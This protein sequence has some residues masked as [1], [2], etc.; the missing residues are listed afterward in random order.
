MKA[1]LAAVNAKYIHSNLAVYC[2]RSYASRWREQIEIAEYTINQYTDD[3]LRD[4]YLKQ[5]DFLAFSCYIWNISQVRELAAELRKLCPNMPIWAGGPE[6]SYDSEE[7]LKENPAFTGIMAGEGE[8]TFYKLMEYYQENEGNLTDVRGLVF[9]DEEGRIVHNGP[10]EVIDLDEL[11]FP[12][13]DMQDFEHKIVYYETSRGCPFSCS[14]CLSS[15]DK[16]VRFRS[17]ELVKNELMFF[18]EHEVPQV[19][20]VDR[21][22]NCNHGQAVEIWKYIA[23]HDRGITNFHF[24]IAADLLNE[25]ELGLINSMRPGLIQLEIGVQSTRMTTLK[26]IQRETDFK[27][28]QKRVRR[29]HEAGNVHQH[30]DLIAGLPHEDYGRFQRS[31]DD[32]Y[33]LEP[34]QLQ[35]GFLKVLKGS[36]MREAA[37]EFGLV[38]K[39]CP[40][41]EVLS[42]KWIRYDE[43]LKLKAVEQMVEVYYNSGQFRHTLKAAVPKLGSPYAFYEAL[44]GYYESRG[45]D[46]RN[47]SRMARYEILYEWLRET[48]G[49]WQDQYREL[50]TYDFYLR[51]NAKNPP[52]FAPDQEP[53]RDGV[54]SFYRME[55]KSRKYLK[56]YKGCTSRQLMTMTH[57][58]VFHY[59]VVKG[60]MRPGVYPVLFDYKRRDPL[61]HSA[62]NRKVKIGGN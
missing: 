53:Y 23:E 1:I 42:T 19:K 12:Y 62:W 54:R 3:I 45:Y 55:E 51:E 27:R 47:H 32:V 11:P 34:D 36:R 40:P 9:K 30:L 35:L 7:F 21:T 61:D 44:A 59:D 18:I 29:I 2:L 33:D 28:I 24:E 37:E 25:E 13:E 43:I 38:Y 10:G 49:E 8:K 22:F 39:S 5:P 16:R 41:Y 56:G 6:V 4:I 50:L 31:F 57:L 17:L 46:G 26:A 48:D 20:F 14:Y 52:S 58:E 60:S 15:I